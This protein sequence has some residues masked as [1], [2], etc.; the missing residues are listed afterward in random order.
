MTRADRDGIVQRLVGRY[1]HNTLGETVVSDD[2]C[3]GRLLA[4]LRL[5]LEDRE[6]AVNLCS[7]LVA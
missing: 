1:D 2:E 3:L 5:D 4:T 7:Y 6:V